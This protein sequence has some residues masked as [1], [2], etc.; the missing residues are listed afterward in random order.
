LEDDPDLIEPQVLAKD[1]K[2]FEDGDET[3]KQKLIA[4]AKNRGC[5]GWDIGKNIQ[6]TPHYRRPHPCLVWTGPGRKIPKIVMRKGGIVHMGKVT[7][8]PTGYAGSKETPNYE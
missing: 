5:V 3:L 4:R 8:M 7:D 1:K 2:K 6:S